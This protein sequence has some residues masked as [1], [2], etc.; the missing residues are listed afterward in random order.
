[1]LLAAITA[2]AA[3]R[4]DLTARAGAGLTAHAMCSAVFV[5]GLDPDTTFREFVKPHMGDALGAL[6]DWRLDRRGQT[7]N[8]SFA[9]VFR[10][11]AEYRAGYGCRLS[12][13]GNTPAS[14]DETAV[15]ITPTDGF[16]AGAVVRATD[17]A[18]GRAVER[19]FAE[20]IGERPKRVKALV[21]A[22]DGRVI[23]ERYAPGFGPDTPLLS[24]SVAKSV[25][26]ALLGILVRQGRM[27]VG[28]RVAAPEWSVTDARS[29]ITLED[30]LRMRSGLDAAE[31]GSGFD[32]TTRMLYTQSDMAAY[33]AARPLARAPGKVFE[34]TSANTLLLDRAIGRAVGDGAAGLRSF[35][36]SELFG[37]LGMSSVTME[38]DGAGTFVGSSYVYAPARAFARFGALYA[39]DGVAPDGRR[40][41]PA[42]WADW[43][44]R[45]TLGSPY[46]GGFWTNDGP[47]AL[48]TARVRLGLPPD[49]M[50]ASG[51]LGQRIYIV[52]SAR[53]VVARFGDSS[54]PA[55]GIEDDIALIAAVVRSLPG[56]SQAA[57][58]SPG[59][60][61]N[62]STAAAN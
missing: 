31:T 38:F 52:P 16:A 7:V 47:S 59:I 10:S 48:A 34:Y 15:G 32:P 4:L 45:S 49:A 36:Q 26:N 5:S 60:K 27:R 28:D 9:W 54:P 35:A 46:G 18:I 19:V 29:A 13:P 30:L 39:V 12:L 24:Y 21:V 33:A 43:S 41:L 8:A 3:V 11:R 37:P 57:G 40:I 62:A 58:I 53:L 1:M 42:G 56:T 44:R 55:F 2:A 22:V 23:A 6:L 20:R 51:N 14:E 25:T 50:I 61:R 17:P